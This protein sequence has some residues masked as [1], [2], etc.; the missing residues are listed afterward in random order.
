MAKEF[1]R[2]KASSKITTLLRLQRYVSSSSGTSYL[3]QCALIRFGSQKLLP[4]PEP[5]SICSVTRGFSSSSC[6]TS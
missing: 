6:H 4:N 3:I 5:R 2:I 1:K